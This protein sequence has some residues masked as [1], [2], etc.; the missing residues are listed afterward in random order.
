MFFT[1]YSR[2]ERERHS[3]ERRRFEVARTIYP[4]IIKICQK[5]TYS[6]SSALKVPDSAS[7]ITV[8]CADAL[9]RELDKN[10]GS[11]L[12]EVEQQKGGDQ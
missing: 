2:K 11:Q 6:L 1:R 3:R 7:Y 5:N 12:R 8:I 9:L 10:E 4:T